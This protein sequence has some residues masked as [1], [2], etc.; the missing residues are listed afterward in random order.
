MKRL[1]LLFL[2]L[3]S[4]TV[5][6]NYQGRLLFRAAL[7]E[8]P[9]ADYIPSYAAACNASID[10]QIARFP[11]YNFTNRINQIS[12]AQCSI[13]REG[14]MQIFS[15]AVLKDCLGVRTN[16]T[17]NYNETNVVCAGEPNCPNGQTLTNGACSTDCTSF[18]GKRAEFSINCSNGNIPGSVCMPNNC[19]ANVID[20]VLAQNRTSACWF[21]VG[22][23][24][25]TGQECSG[26][27]STSALSNPSNANPA[28]EDSPETKCIKEGKS[29]GSVNGV[30][31]CVPKS[32]S[33]GAPIKSSSESTTK[34][35]ETDE[36]GNQTGSGSTTTKSE[37]S[38]DGD[39]VVTKETKKDEDGK[40]TTV[41]TETTKDD[42]CQKNPNHAICKAEPDDVCEENPDL[43]QCMK[44]GEPDAGGLIETQART[45]SYTPVQITSGGSCPP[46]KTVSI[47]GRAITFSY[48][49]LCQYA[50]MFKPFMLAFAYLSAAMF[51]FSGLRG[52]NT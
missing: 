48:S 28:P 40:T 5:F 7:S 50:S 51:L 15:I 2:L 10:G 24:K 52:A 30:T 13:V 1:L 19:A 37:L 33:G 26:Q 38:K 23:G 43:P 17:G 3:A 18:T 8:V 34:T 16:W 35:T 6:A 9:N 47:A 45:V 31:V 49:W 41:E 20:S 36:N 12:P 42:F 14:N 29:F 27:T 39:A 44:V 32:S 11:G 21:G 25:Y 46:D 4:S 22:T